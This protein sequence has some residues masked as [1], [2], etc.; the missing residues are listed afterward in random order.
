MRQQD[1]RN[2]TVDE[3]LRSDV[4]AG[5][6]VVIAHGFPTSLTGKKS[7]NTDEAVRAAATYMTSSTSL[8]FSDRGHL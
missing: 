7:V 3:N 1:N 6:Q 4:L 8:S 2:T 5:V